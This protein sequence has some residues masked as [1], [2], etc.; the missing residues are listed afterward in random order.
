ME[1]LLQGKTAS[2]QDAVDVIDASLQKATK[3]NN[4]QAIGQ[5]QQMKSQLTTWQLDNPAMGIKAGDP[6]PPD[7]PATQL[8]DLK[9]GLREQ[10]IKNWNPTYM[11][12]TRSIAAQSAHA[13]DASLDAA[14]GADFPIMNQQLS[15]LIPAADRADAVALSPTLGQRVL[16]RVGARTGALAA[17]TGGGALGYKEGGIPG[18]LVGAA[19]G[20]VVPEMLAD[21]TAQMM[22]ARALHSGMPPK[23]AQALVLSIVHGGD[24]EFSQGQKQ[25]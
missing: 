10:W 25:P 24:T 20:A 9:R 5:L 11:K 22:L 1:A 15:S 7:M 19:T 8:L 17:A 3:Q 2:V 4:A 6:I 13:A 21:P 18:A 12:G 14:G 23:V 16:G